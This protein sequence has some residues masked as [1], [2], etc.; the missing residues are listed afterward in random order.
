MYLSEPLVT[1]SFYLTICRIVSE[2][3]LLCSA[4][5]QELSRL[6]GRSQSA[7]LPYHNLCS[8]Y[9]AWVIFAV[10]IFKVPRD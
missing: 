7:G 8:Y 6:V 5:N 2:E 3:H 1:D 9:T 10:K 4:A